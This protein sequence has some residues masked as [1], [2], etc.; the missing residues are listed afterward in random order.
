MRS[1]FPPEGGEW[2]F[3]FLGPGA[4]RVKAAVGARLGLDTWGPA[5]KVDFGF[6]CVMLRP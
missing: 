5:P 1:A 4:P 2:R 6:G 3:I